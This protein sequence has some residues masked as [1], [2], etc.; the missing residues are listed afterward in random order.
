MPINISMIVSIN[1]IRKFIKV[2]KLKDYYKL[3]SLIKTSSTYCPCSA[4]LRT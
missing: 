4:G 2:K 1:E 3:Q